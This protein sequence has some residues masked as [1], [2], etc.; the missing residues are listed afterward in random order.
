MFGYSGTRVIEVCRDLLSR[1]SI[2][3]YPFRC[4]ELTSQVMPLLQQDFQSTT[5]VVQTVEDLIQELEIKLA[6]SEA[7]RP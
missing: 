6:A 4:D 1:A 2:G 5:Q 3:R 7:K